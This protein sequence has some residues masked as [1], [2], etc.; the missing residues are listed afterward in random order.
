M[1]AYVTQHILGFQL[2]LMPPIL[3]PR[4]GP[5]QEQPDD[6]DNTDGDDQR[7]TDLRAL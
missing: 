4:Q 7:P 6:V 3:Q 2:P 1:Q 5:T